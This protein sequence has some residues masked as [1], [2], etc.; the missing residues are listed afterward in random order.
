MNEYEREQAFTDRYGEAL[1]NKVAASFGC[2]NIERVVDRDTQIRGVDYFIWKTAIRSIKQEV[3]IKIDHY[4]NHNFAFELSSQYNGIGEASWVE[5]DDNIWIAYFKVAL[6]KVY[7]FKLRDLKEFRNSD[8]F[9]ER[10]IVETNYKI[11]GK[12]ATFKNFRLDE[13]PVHH[14]V[15]VELFYNPFTD[16][17]N[18][19]DVK[20]S[21]P[22]SKLYN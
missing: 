4:N 6:K 7:I 5:H 16:D 3:D 10:K 20:E 11:N 15:D 13:L 1:M 14:I 2:N 18:L 17:K 19:L 12:P 8:V 22:D 9:A 21:W